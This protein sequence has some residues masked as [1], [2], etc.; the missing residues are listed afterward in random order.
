MFDVDQGNHLWRLSWRT[1]TT[2]FTDRDHFETVR[3]HRSFWNERERHRTKRMCTESLFFSFDRVH[4]YIRE[5]SKR[6]VDVSPSP[7]HLFSIDSNK[8]RIQFP[9]SLKPLHGIV[10]LLWSDAESMPWRDISRGFSHRNVHDSFRSG[11]FRW[12]TISLSEASTRTK[13]YK[14]I[15][16]QNAISYAVSR[17]NQIDIDPRVSNRH[18][19]CR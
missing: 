15:L 10:F 8:Q 7:W 12:P 18:H 19:S 11:I 16:F 2:R 4:I 9:T 17:T 1:W 13:Y 6:Q 14:S 3:I 5:T